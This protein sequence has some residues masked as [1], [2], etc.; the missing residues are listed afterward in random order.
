MIF[1]SLILDISPTSGVQLNNVSEKRRCKRC[2][3]Y[4]GL[5]L[6]QREP[7]RCNAC[8]AMK[9]R[10]NTSKENRN[11][12]KHRSP[13][14]VFFRASLISGANADTGK[15]LSLCM[16]RA[17]SDASTI[18]EQQLD[19][20]NIKMYI[21]VD[22]NMNLSTP[23][24]DENIVSTRFRSTPQIIRHISEFPAAYDVAVS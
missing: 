17:F 24:G 6:F 12:K 9:E 18:V 1:F 22:I 3:R 4:L 2:C 7:D 11:E 19:D 8:V 10:L 16:Q 21:T 20:K 5:H 13:K 23:D 15:D 14:D